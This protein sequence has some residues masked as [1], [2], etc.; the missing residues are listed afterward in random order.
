MPAAEP[1]TPQPA[2]A[3]PASSSSPCRVPSSPMGPWITGKTQPSRPSPRSVR[4]GSR[5]FAP[6]APRVQVLGS[7]RGELPRGELEPVTV[8]RDADE[9]HAEAG[10]EQVLDDAAGRD[11]GDQ[12]LGGAPAAE[13]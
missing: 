10:G 9:P 2:Y 6:A 8:A 3:T 11:E 5:A 4:Q 13:D 1:S 12:P 7:R